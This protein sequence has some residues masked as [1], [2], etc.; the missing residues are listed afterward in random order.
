MEA[1][2]KPKDMVPV[3]DFLKSEA[4]QGPKRERVMK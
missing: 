1:S 3:I 2:L 4:Q